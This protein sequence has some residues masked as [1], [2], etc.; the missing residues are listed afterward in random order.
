MCVI[1]VSYYVWTENLYSIF[2]NFGNFLFVVFVRVFNVGLDR[3]EF[4]L[5]STESDCTTSQLD[6]IGSVCKA[7]KLFFDAKEATDWLL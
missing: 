6:A 5:A 2:F 4:M 3:G 1:L 7:S